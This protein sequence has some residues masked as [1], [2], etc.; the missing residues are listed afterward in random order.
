VHVAQLGEGRQVGRSGIV[1]VQQP[2]AAVL[3]PQRRVAD[4]PVGGTGQGL[5]HDHETA[6]E[7]N[8]LVGDR[9]DEPGEAQVAQLVLEL[10]RGVLGQQDRGALGD[11][12]RE[13]L[14]VEV[15]PVQVGHVEVVRVS[16]AV[17]V[18]L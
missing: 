17:P 3:H 6:A 9:S 11:V 1:L 7:L 4:R 14:R 13:V 10:A 12:A 15:V 18:E 2:D 5:D 8:D 16:Q